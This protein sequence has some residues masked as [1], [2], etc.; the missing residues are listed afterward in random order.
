L[1]PALVSLVAFVLYAIGC[2]TFGSVFPFDEYSLYSDT[3]DRRFSAAPVFQAG[4]VTANPEDFHR[5]NGFD[6][7][8]FLPLDMPTGLSWIALETGRWIGEHASVG[9]DGP[10]E[11]DYGFIKYS[12]AEEGGIDREVLILCRGTAWP[13]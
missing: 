10:V 7:F 11:V 12:I 1:D 2:K 8:N 5:F 9:M 13:R 3:S 4:G 6:G